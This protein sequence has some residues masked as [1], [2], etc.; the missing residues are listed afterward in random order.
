MIRL[1]FSPI[2]SPLRADSQGAVRVGGTRVTL[3]TL[4]GCY[5]DGCTAEEIVQQFP[6]LSLADVHAA[7][8]YYLTHQ[9]DVE[10]YLH[11]RESEAERLRRDASQVS[12]QRGIRERLIGRRPS[13]KPGP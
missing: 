5:R 6:A 11:S 7:I 10:A 4:I 9:S 3:D 12:D 13:K 8:A 1:P 2:E